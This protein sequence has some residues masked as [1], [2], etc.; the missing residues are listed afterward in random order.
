MFEL[1]QTLHNTYGVCLWTILALIVFAI[2]LVW[3][4]VHLYK[5]KRRNDKFEKE[6]E[7]NNREDENGR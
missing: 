2:M 4:I 1:H 3:T 7:D 6:L 5:Q